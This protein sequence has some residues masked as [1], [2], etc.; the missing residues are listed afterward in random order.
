MKEKIFVIVFMIIIFTTCLFNIFTKKQDISLYERRKLASN[1]NITFE[2]LLNKELTNDIDKYVADHFILRDKLRSIKVNFEFLLNKSD[3]NNLFYYKG[4]YFKYEDKYSERQI[5]NFV[6]KI[7]YIYDNYFENMNVYLAVIPEKGYYLN[8]SKYKKFAYDKLFKTLEGINNNIKYID[9]TNTI[10]LD[11]YYYTDHHLRQD[12]LLP[13]IKKMANIM[14]FEFNNDY[15][16][17]KY[18]PFYGAYFGQLPIKNKGEKLYVLNNEVTKNATVYNIENSYNKIYEYSK[19][20]TIDSY[21]IFLSG[22]TAYEEL[23]N[24]S[25]KKDKELII[26]RDSYTSSFAPLILEGYSKITL[27]DIRYGNLSYLMDKIN[28]NNQDV[29]FLYSTSLIN[30]SDVLR[31]S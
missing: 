9:I 7:N 11:S 6:D 2:G 18:E 21:D 1:I 16:I 23:Y 14:N 28:I 3:V 10:A 30:G 24:N 17:D 31:T 20:G 27:I 22:A 25:E 8:N 19:F 15:S 26:F 29:L 5:N 4:Q 13:T 12:K